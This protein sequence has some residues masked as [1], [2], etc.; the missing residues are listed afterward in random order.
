MF[1]GFS[2]VQPSLCIAGPGGG[3]GFRRR[4]T[5]GCRQKGR[6]RVFGKSLA[7]PGVERIEVREPGVMGTLFLPPGVGKHPVIIVLSGS[8]GGTYEPAAWIGLRTKGIR[9]R[10]R[11]SIMKLPA[12]R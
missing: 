5:G 4:D 8:E 3:D 12:T 7:L 6:N 9:S 2:I 1:D 10:T 11:I